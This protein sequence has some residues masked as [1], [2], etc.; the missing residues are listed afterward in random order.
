MRRIIKGLARGLL[1]LVPV[2]LLAAGAA[3]LYFS[4]ALP[5][6]DGAVQIAGLA[7]PVTITRDREGV[8]HIS[9]GNAS[10][11]AAGLGFAHAQDRLWQMHVSRM[12]GKGRLSEL[13]GAA[14]IGTDR[15]LRT[16]AID[17]A[18]KGSLA[19]IDPPTQAML[20]GYARGV[21]AWL[22]EDGRTFA[23]PLPI[24]FSILGVAPEPWSPLDTLITI[25]MMS[26]SLANNV[27]HEVQ[28][29]S[30]ARL[31]LTPAE[32]EDLMPP[33]AADAPPPLPEL[34]E[35]LGLDAGPLQ[36][37]TAQDGQNASL[38]PVGAFFDEITA[39][40]ASNNW[41]VGGARTASGK[42]VV[43]N[44]PHLGLTA[45][46]IWYLAHLEVTEEFGA[47]RNLVGAS[48][49]GAPFVF[50]GRN[51]FA[52]WGYTNT[53][54]DVQ[55]I[56]IERVNPDNPEEYL[57]PTGWAAFGSARETI[58]VKGGADVVFTRR[59]TRH[60][61]VLPESY[62]NIAAYLPENSVA[63]LQW[64]AL[65]HDDTTANA[66][67]RLFTVESVADYQ[68][69]MEPF[70]TPMQ[71]MVV[72]DIDGNIGFIAPG[73]AP[74]R[75]PRNLV[76]GRAPV[77]GWD[78]IYDWQGYLP[79]AELPRQ[80]NPDKGAIG[81]A[82]TKIVSATYPHFLTYD[83]DRGFRQERVDALIIDAEAPHTPE[84]SREAQADVYSPGLVRLRDRFTQLL[85][86]ADLTV[87]EEGVLR[88]LERWD[89]RMAAGR[90]EPLLMMGWA[91]QMMIETYADDLGP[92]FD[93][94]LKIRPDT[95]ERNFNGSAA[96]D[97]CDRT[98]TD[99][100]EDC[101]DT[102]QLALGN[103]LS[104]LKRRYGSD[105]EAWD[106]AE[107]HTARGAHRP[108]SQVDLLARFFD[109]SVPHQGGPFT[110]DR[111]QTT[112]N[113]ADQP[114]T[115]THAASFR[116]I[117]DLADLNRS[118][119]IQTTGQSGNVFSRHYRDMAERWARVEAI[120]I[121]TGP[122]KDVKGTWRLTPKPD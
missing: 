101:A 41:V 114:Y 18:A 55:D 22:A 43:A 26:V 1:V 62:K 53:A 98:G 46:S 121:P 93:D 29:L 28:R 81:T 97:W 70:L 23:A 74:V 19:V 96:R 36:K 38:S 116:G 7:G 64:V 78:E 71:S 6:R 109:V 110:L 73:R 82:N 92:A 77:P 21:N 102:A 48:L 95:L 42:P 2:V 54:T 83:W 63:A 49:A 20:E 4:R 40:R 12:A 45:P 89:G 17:K 68:A 99:Q 25:K 111:G 65:A 118:T 56:F 58:K 119:F 106:W 52:A 105:I 34:A 94:W 80:T 87:E 117:Y 88:R 5:E 59:W 33:V 91:R 120:E 24:E 107:V 37:G 13:F 8:P 115:N 100:R 79:F 30:F 60:G 57:T 11:A 103:A 84:L 50:L 112:L 86:D 32:I 72:A 51:D 10:D 9:A 75:D 31:G 14:T 104:D 69:A 27:G 67:P 16:M 61:P 90:S 85:Q 122:V 3:F 44:D 76:E 113:D 108:F 66:G 35:L 15:W 39:E 47:P